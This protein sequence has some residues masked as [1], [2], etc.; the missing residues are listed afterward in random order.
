MDELE[1]SGKR[2]ISTRRAGKE[3]NYHS[4]YIGQLIRGGK[5]EGR[6][7]GRAWYVREDSLTT[8]LG[9]ELKKAELLDMQ[10]QTQPEVVVATPAPIF[11]TKP[12][13]PIVVEEKIIE[14]PLKVAIKIEREIEPV[15][16]RY[17]DE[18][19]PFLPRIEKRRSVEQYRTSQFVDEVQQS[20]E[21]EVVI[22]PRVSKPRSPILARGTVIAAIGILAFGVS[23]G[24]L[25][26]LGYH[27][28]VVKG[29]GMTASV[30]LF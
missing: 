29:S 23:T 6:K 14:E 16:L 8:Y 15:V 21:E 2:Y 13:Q 1:I 24:A 22:I 9:K 25:Y 17:A 28:T 3:H 4:D 20:N 5:V 18:D 19:E 12:T 11:E 7:V 10:P 30:G 27:A 26:I